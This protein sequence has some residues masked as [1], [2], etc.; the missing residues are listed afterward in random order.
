MD[1]LLTAVAAFAGSLVAVLLW[2]TVGKREQVEVILAASRAAAAQM[3]TQI[4]AE[5]AANDGTSLRD[6]VDRLEE[7]G[8]RI[9]AASSVVADDLAA[10]HDRADAA[11]GGIAGEAADAASRSPRCPHLSMRPSRLALSRSRRTSSACTAAICSTVTGG[12][13]K[14]SCTTRAMSAR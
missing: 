13:W 4:R 8:V 5:F 11:H 14:A 9:E 6:A 10:A 12:S 1:L 2:Q 3:L 7:S